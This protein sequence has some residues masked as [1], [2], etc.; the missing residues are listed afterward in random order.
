MPRN[1]GLDRLD[2]ESNERFHW[3]V[4]RVRKISVIVTVLILAGA[5]AGLFGPGP[6]STVEATAPGSAF[7]I[8]YSRFA[9]L[10]SPMELVLQVPSI[11]RDGA[12][13]VQL[14]VQIENEYLRHFDLE[15]ITPEPLQTTSSAGYTTY[16]FESKPPGSVL[17]KIRM[18]AQKFGRVS[19]S[20][21]AS[22]GETF[23][24]SHFIYP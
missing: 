19:G 24:L 5:L 4:Q 15:R 17:I 10:D 3:K 13:D 20:V 2:A 18:R 6:I 23:R 22:T 7:K 14:D 8:Q 12:A 9:R 16:A 1:D 11:G 21:R